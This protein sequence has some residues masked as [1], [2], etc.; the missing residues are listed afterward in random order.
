VLHYRSGVR[1]PV[2]LSPRTLGVIAVALSLGLTYLAVKTPWS[3]LPR[4]VI[5]ASGVAASVSLWFRARLPV[6]VAA[7]C[8]AAYAL[9]GNP[10]PLLVSLFSGVGARLS[11]RVPALAVIGVAAVTAE[12]LISGTMDNLLPALAL[13]ATAM[14]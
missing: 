7:V 3:S 11:W 6:T 10:G 9:S 4:P 8:G 13:T 5:A 14:A 2:A 1:G 12:E